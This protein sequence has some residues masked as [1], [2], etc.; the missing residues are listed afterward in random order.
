MVA[1]RPHSTLNLKDRIFGLDVCTFQ[2]LQVFFMYYTFNLLIY[3]TILVDIYLVLFQFDISAGTSKMASTS[4]AITIL[5]LHIF[6]TF[7]LTH[8]Y[9]GF[10]DTR[11]I[12]QQQ[13]VF[14]KQRAINRQHYHQQV[15][16]IIDC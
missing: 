9:T 13:C 10:L 8:T 16:Y 2:N 4:V 7:Y 1:K 15:T 5:Y 14:C 6:H 12:F 3:C 11:N